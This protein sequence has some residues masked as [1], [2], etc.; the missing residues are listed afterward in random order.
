M[1]IEEKEPEVAEVEKELEHE[2]QDTK[3]IPTTIFRPTTKTVPNEEIIESS[4]RPQLT[5]RD[6]DDSP[7]KLVKATREI[8]P[9]PNAPILID[10]K[11][12]EVMYELINEEIQAHLEKKEQMEK[13]AQEVKL[14]ELSKPELIKVVKEVVSEARVDP[15]VLRIIKGGKEFLKQHDAEYKVLQKEHLEKLKNLRDLK[16]K[17]FDQYVWTTQNRLKPEKITDILIYPNT[18]PVTITVYRNNDRRNFDVH[19]N[20]K[21][22]DFGLSE[23]DELSVI[24][25]KNK[26]K[27]VSELM[28][29]LSKK[30]EWLKE[31]PGELGINPSL[32]LP[33]QDLSLS[34][35][36]K[37]KQI[38]LE[39]EVH[40]AGLECD[41]SLHE[42]FQF[43]NNKVIETPKYEIFFINV[44]G[45][46]AFQRINDIHKV[47]VESLL[48][49][50][51]MA[52]N[53]NT[54]RNQRFC[55]LMRK[56]IDEHPDKDKLKSKRVKLEAIGYSF[57]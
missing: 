31:I 9:D 2:P 7:L 12:Y 15:K 40:I 21:F 34:S 24:I 47:E 30:C 42:G 46:E 43:V 5:T 35:S 55:V 38:E 26:N 17:I 50:I 10:Y 20:F 32:P 3:P 41:R 18:R 16:K 4:L 27:V 51:V 48:G 6:T 8:R 45:D 56:M 11:I 29:S 37:R 54:P 33:E 1:A 36:R 22:G 53:I 49:Y 57:S 19:K 25:P 23:W 14:I 28:T 44:F 52:G 13:A 39:P